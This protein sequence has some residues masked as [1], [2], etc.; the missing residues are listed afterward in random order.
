MNAC[1]W[2]LLQAHD[3]DIELLAG[4]QHVKAFA[5]FILQFG[6]QHLVR[7][8]VPVPVVVQE[9]QIRQGDL[10]LD[11]IGHVDDV[12]FRGRWQRWYR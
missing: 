5:D 7:G 9:F 4:S 12:L 1:S 2:Y 3:L 11:R 8:A 10:T 6:G